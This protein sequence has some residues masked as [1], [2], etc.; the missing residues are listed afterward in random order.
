MYHTLR[1][2]MSRK[3]SKSDL[4]RADISLLINSEE[5]KNNHLYGNLYDILLQ[6]K[7]LRAIS[8]D[9]LKCYNLNHGG[10]AALTYNRHTLIDNATREWRAATNIIDN[11]KRTAACQLCNAPKLR[12]ECYIYNIK[13]GTELL[14][15]SECVNHFKIDGYLNQKKQLAQIHIGQ[16]IAQR[17]N[18]FYSR[19]PDYEDFIFDAERYFSTLPILLPYKL[20]ISLEDTISRMKLIAVK[21]V[22]EGKKPYDSKYDSFDLFRL[23]VDNYQK[24]KTDSDNYVNINI[25]EK[26]V[27]KRP[28]MD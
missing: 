26:F 20:Y 21:Y 19:F 14:V 6:I 2:N 3:L 1:R 25:G 16:K 13:N 9:E 12:Y 17:K 23:A 7:D 11:P 24:L 4:S 15:G 5:A 18:E 27:C 22:N 28:E 8:L 10:I